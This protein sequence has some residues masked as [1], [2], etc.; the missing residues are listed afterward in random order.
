MTF[1]VLVLE[2]SRSVQFRASVIQKNR[3]NIN[4]PLTHTT[5]GAKAYLCVDGLGSAHLAQNGRGD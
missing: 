1:F 2:F 5:R 4:A 3:W